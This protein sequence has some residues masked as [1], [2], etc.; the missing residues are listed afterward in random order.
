M[1]RSSEPVVHRPSMEFSRPESVNYKNSTKSMQIGDKINLRLIDL[2]HSEVFFN[3]L[4]DVLSSITQHIYRN[5]I[6]TIK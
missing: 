5:L 4:L 6:S 3:K 1:I 2:G